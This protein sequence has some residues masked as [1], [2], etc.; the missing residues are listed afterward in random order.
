MS[1]QAVADALVVPT[2]PFEK[3]AGE[4]AGPAVE[5]VAHAEVEYWFWIGR[6]DILVHGG[7]IWRVMIGIT[8]AVRV[9]GIQRKPLKKRPIRF[10]WA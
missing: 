4:E 2:G 9:Q 5:S 6:K 1:D 8:G 7:D 3:A 10:E